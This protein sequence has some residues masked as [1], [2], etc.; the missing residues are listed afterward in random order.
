M[1]LVTCAPNLW[2]TITTRLHRGTTVRSRMPARAAGY[3]SRRR[4]RPISSCPALSLEGRSKRSAGTTSA[5]RILETGA[6]PAASTSVA[7]ASYVRSSRLVYIN[8]IGLDT[9][10]A[11]WRPFVEHRIKNPRRRCLPPHESESNTTDRRRRHADNL[12]R[13]GALGNL[14]SSLTMCAASYV[15]LRVLR[16]QERA[17][18]D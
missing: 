5:L 13:M 8:R 15:C 12:P 3:D 4:F 18:V 10:R 2:P 1:L 11:L 7:V 6:C 17:A 16:S 14:V 9:I